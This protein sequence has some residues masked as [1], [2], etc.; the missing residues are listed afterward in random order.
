MLTLPVSLGRLL[1][2]V[3]D[4]LKLFN[5]AGLGSEFPGESKE[6]DFMHVLDCHGNNAVVK[7]EHLLYM[8]PNLKLSPTTSVMQNWKKQQK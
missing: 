4:L 1:K 5:P 8:L 6:C 3:N 7:T 2:H